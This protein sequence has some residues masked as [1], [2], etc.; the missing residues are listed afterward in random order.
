MKQLHQDMEAIRERWQ[1]ASHE[2]GLIRASIM[3]RG[4]TPKAASPPPID[5]H[6]LAH[7]ELES[8][9]QNAG[10]EGD[11]ENA[12]LSSQPVR[13][14]QLPTIASLSMPSHVAPLVPLSNMATLGDDSSDSGSSSTS[15]SASAVP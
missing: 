14:V 9:L 3:A 13:L 2:V 4:F 7:E 5:D 12:G 8:A 6:A 15:L 11:E 1:V 10:F